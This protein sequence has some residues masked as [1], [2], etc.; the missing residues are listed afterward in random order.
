MIQKNT[1]LEPPQGAPM[2]NIEIQPGHGFFSHIVGTNN[3]NGTTSKVANVAGRA[4]LVGAA[5]YGG[6]KLFSK[7]EP[8]ALDV[9]VGGFE[10]A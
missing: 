2:E 10:P 6:I 8:V 7:D 1:Y 5:V 9:T 4:A 3:V